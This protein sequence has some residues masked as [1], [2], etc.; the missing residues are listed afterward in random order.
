MVKECIFCYW[1]PII[2]IFIIPLVIHSCFIIV[3]SLK[4]L[5]SFNVFYTIWIFRK[6]TQVKPVKQKEERKSWDIPLQKPKIEPPKEQL[7]F[8]HKQSIQ[9]KDIIYKL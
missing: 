8:K 5:I 3:D 9:A 4:Y 7:M 2:E 6:E 1:Q